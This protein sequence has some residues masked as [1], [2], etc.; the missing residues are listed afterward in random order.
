MNKIYQTLSLVLIVSLVLLPWP[1]TA[2]AESRSVAVVQVFVG[3]PDPT[4]SAMRDKISTFLSNQKGVNLVAM[5]KFASSQRATSS[6]YVPGDKEYESAKN[7]FI[8]F[9]FNDALTFVDRAISSLQANPGTQGTITKAYVLKAGIFWELKNEPM[10]QQAI[11][12]AVSYNLDM[13]ALDEYYYSTKM[14]NFYSRAYQTFQENNKV[15]TMS[16]N[17]KNASMMPIIVNG[18]LRGVGPKLTI[19]VPKGVPQI[20]QVQNNIYS[21]T[22]GNGKNKYVIDTTDYQGTPFSSMADNNFTYLAED[23]QNIGSTIKADQVA[24]LKLRKKG[25]SKELLLKV[26]DVKNGNASGTK[27]YTLLSIDK[28]GDQVARM[29]SDYIASLHS[30]SQFSK[31]LAYSWDLHQPD[32]PVKDPPKK[33]GKTA[34]IIGGAAVVVIGGIIAGVALSSGGGNSG[35]GSGSG[36]AT[37]TTTFSGP[38]P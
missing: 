1:K 9:K 19:P 11:L 30:R 18:H 33:L 26:V 13:K 7:L 15:V 32:K 14:I 25:K 3:K 8:D 29:A 12:D 17:L 27:Y 34:W 28:D 20:I 36:S 38:A 10:A 4:L 22:P 23:A 2:R 6:K 31:E 16:I 5:N 35:S 37:T 24:Y 21:Y